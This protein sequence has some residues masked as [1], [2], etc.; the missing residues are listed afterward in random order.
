MQLL[1]NIRTTVT[2]A[3]LVIATIAFVIVGIVITIKMTGKN[4]QGFREAFSSIGGVMLGVCVIGA[5]GVLVSASTAIAA[6][7][8]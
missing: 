8:G 7:L 3:G 4:A 6:L 5:A 1:E 2:A